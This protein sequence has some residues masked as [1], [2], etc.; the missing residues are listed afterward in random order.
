MK[1]KMFEEL[2][3]EHI[4]QDNVEEEI[5]Q[6]YIKLYKEDKGFHFMICEE[7]KIVAIGGAVIKSDV[8]FC[9]FKSPYYGYII[10]VYC[11]PEKRRKGYATE[12]MKAILA[13]LKEK[14]I[15][16]VKLKP[17]NIGKALYEKFGFCSSD[18]MELMMKDI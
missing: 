5:K 13:L 7:N 12:I 14:K 9:F 4:F 18:E 1:M 15:N 11:I 8:P 17:S 2:G 6:E 16:V 10:D 3:I